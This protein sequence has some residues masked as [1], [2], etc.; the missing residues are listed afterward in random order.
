MGIA[1]GKDPG[2]LRNR[3]FKGVEVN[4]VPIAV[5][6]QGRINDAAVNDRV[7]DKVVV[8]GRLD[9]Y[10][11]SRRYVDLEGEIE[12]CH[13]GREEEDLLFLISQW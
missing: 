12:A 8:D 6:Y 3:F 4:L 2:S 9:H 5:A 11:V 7:S 1:E 13:H 10:G